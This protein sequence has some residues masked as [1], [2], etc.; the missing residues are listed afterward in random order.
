MIPR[1][2]HSARPLRYRLDRS[3]RYSIMRIIGWMAPTAEGVDF[4]PRNP[5]IKKILLVRA[6]FRMGNALLALPAIAAFRKQFPNAVIDFVGSPISHLLFR[7]QPLD[8]HYIAPRRFP[9]V[10]W[11][12]PGL[13]RE[14]RAQ[15]YDLAVDVSCSHSGLASFIVGLSGA[16]IRAGIDGKWDQLFNLKIA[17][18]AEENKYRKMT[19]LL[20]AMRLEAIDTVGALELSDAERA[21]GAR[22]LAAIVDQRNALAVGVFV[23]GRKL[24]GKR[25]PLENFVEIAKG[26]RRRGIAV[27]VFLGPEE[28]DIAASLRDALEPSIPVVFEPSIRKFAG[29]VAQLGLLICCDSGPMHLACAVGTRVLAIF[30]RGDVG[31]WAPPPS[32]ARSLSGLDGAGTDMV[33]QAALEELSLDGT[34]SVLP[35]GLGSAATVAHS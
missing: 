27:A 9:R 32:A 22:T 6:N 28:K 31:R 10:V 7:R 24:R 3:I 21:E 33:L 12:Y 34:A 4:D 30:Q 15:R 17:K 18:L 25:W 26:L 14:L 29:L 2:F 1:L 20:T 5:S 13:L 23:G 35:S 16:R 19:E 11:E 8:R